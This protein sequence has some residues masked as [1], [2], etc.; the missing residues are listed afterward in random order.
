MKAITTL[1]IQTVPRLPGIEFL[2]DGRSYVTGPEGRV[3]VAET[4]GSHYVEVKGPVRPSPGVRIRFHGWPDPAL[5]SDLLV[6]LPRQDYLQAGFVVS[7]PITLRFVGPAGEAVPD[8]AVRQV[9][10]TSNTGGRY[11][12]SPLHPPSL[13]VANYLAT[14]GVSLVALPIR[15]RVNSVVIEAGDAVYAGKQSFFVSA[16]TPWT[17]H[18]LLFPLRIV[19]RDALFG[20]GF[21]SAVKVSFPNGRERLFALGPGQ[22]VTIPKLPRSDYKLVAKGWGFGLDS[23]VT[24]SRPQTA[25][26]LILSY[27]DITAMCAVALLFLVGLP[28][29][30]RQWLA[31]RARAAD[32]KEMSRPLH[33][34]GT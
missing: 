20:F 26:V 1:V 5:P 22:T 3:I 11:T 31:R 9:V 16:S 6:H 7:R 33:R 23:P 25:K 28:L 8:N 29:V 12:F 21:G 24:L 19:V 17:I 10:L 14:A 13:L 15:Y 18:L 27:Y 32:P 2:V 4:V 34:R 30:G